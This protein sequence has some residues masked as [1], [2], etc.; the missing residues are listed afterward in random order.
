MLLQGMFN[1]CSPSSRSQKG[2]AL[3]G[4]SYTL[5]DEKETKFTTDTAGAQASD[6]R[7][8]VFTQNRLVWVG[9]LGT[10]PKNS[11]FLWFR[12]ENRRFELF[13]DVADIAKKC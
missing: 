5:N 6:I 4:R 2:C 12:L 11:K 9:D 3:T 10:R 1:F 7:H 8:Q 13:S